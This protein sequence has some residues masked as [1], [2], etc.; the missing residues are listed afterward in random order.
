MHVRLGMV[1][2]F[3]KSNNLR[4]SAGTFRKSLLLGCT[5]GKF[6]KL[7][8]KI[9]DYWIGYTIGANFPLPFWIA[10]L[11]LAI[12]IKNLPWPRQTSSWSW[13][14]KHWCGSSPFKVAHI[15]IEAMLFFFPRWFFFSSI[16]TST[17]LTFHIFYIFC[18]CANCHS[19]NFV[20]FISW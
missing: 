6:G 10:I 15:Q 1:Q 4:I 13:K 11:P 19:I 3:G 2:I 8:D 17:H 9:T 16:N 7:P 12:H 20:S 5:I 14:M 18:I